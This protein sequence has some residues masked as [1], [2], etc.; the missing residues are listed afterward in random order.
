MT[1]V[2]RDAPDLIGVIRR[3]V[4]GHD[5]AV[6]R[7]AARGKIVAAKMLGAQSLKLQRP[8][9]ERNGSV[10]RAATR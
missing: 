2:A 8:S 6:I 10:G 3:R 5:P 7:S 1:K 4:E 9:S